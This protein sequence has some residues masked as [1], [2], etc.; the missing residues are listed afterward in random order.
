MRANDDRYWDHRLETLPPDDLARVQDH[1]LQWQMQRCWLGSPFYRARIERAG[2]GQRDV[3]TR[4]DL[5]RLP[6]LTDRELRADRR[7]SP[8]LGSATVAPD[9]WRVEQVS[10]DGP[11]DGPIVLTD[12]DVIHRTGL[13]ARALWAFG[14]RPGSRISVEVAADGSAARASEKAAIRDGVEKIDGEP[15]R[16]TGEADADEPTATSPAPE[17]DQRQRTSASPLLASWR[18][19]V[20]ADGL[21]APEPGSDA[22]YL[23]LGH[24][25]AGVTLAHEC[26]ARAGLHWPPDHYLLEI[27]DP[28]TF[29]PLPD[30]A[31]GALLLTHLTREGSPLIRYWTGYETRL[32]TSPCRCGRTGARST[33]LLPARPLLDEG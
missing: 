19:A 9:E 26:A 28:A 23:A 15:R 11:E 1:R 3:R 22:A 6:V 13:A 18:L 27:V 21:R 25:R 7:A 29:A 14:A 16:N 10:L 17:G 24:P 4:A 32:D 5:T 8:P 12:G 20:P 30:G 31:T 33:A 2:L